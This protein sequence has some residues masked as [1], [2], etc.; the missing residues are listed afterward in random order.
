MGLEK[1]LETNLELENYLT[2]LSVN[3]FTIIENQSLKSEGWVLTNKIVKNILDKLNKMPFRV[4]DIFEKIFQGIATSKDSVYYLTKII[5][6]DD[7]L[8]ECYSQ[9]LDKRILIERELVKPL[10]K[11]DDVHRYQSLVAKKV[12]IF[13]YY[14]FDDSGNKNARL[15]TENEIRDKF[16]NGYDY[17]NQCESILRNREKGRLINDDFWFRYIYPKSLTLFDKEKIIQPDISLGGNFAYDDNGEFYTTTTLYGYIKYPRIKESYKFYMAI[18]NSHLFWWFLQQT[19]T[20]LANNYFR[21]MPMYVEAF[22]I[23]EV[24]NIHETKPF[25]YLVD[26]VIEGKKQGIDTSDQEKEIDKLV[27]ELYGLMDDEIAIIS[28]SDTLMTD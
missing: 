23:P 3:D 11:G 20:I 17:L 1:D 18:L 13:P 15:Y 22:P 6:K 16:P 26:Q 5:E 8:L 4:A 9:E 25:E 12:V 24:T 28:K 19:G 21:F 7:L 10:L 27:Y 14:I 2:N